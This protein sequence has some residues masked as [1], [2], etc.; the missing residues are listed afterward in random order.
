M[1][2]RSFIFLFVCAVLPMFGADPIYY[3][4]LDS[5]GDFSGYAW[6]PS[7]ASVVAALH[8]EYVPSDWNPNF[9]VDPNDPYSNYLVPISPDDYFACQDDSPYKPFSSDPAYASFIPSTPPSG[10]G[11][12]GGGSAPSGGGEGEGGFDPSST[13]NGASTVVGGLAVAVV[14]VIT[15][16]ALICILFIYWRK[17]KTSLHLC[18]DRYGR[19]SYERW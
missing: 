11:G 10:G 14:G 16:A 1:I 7:F 5:V 15:A 9:F 12:G 18:E 8:L 19:I 2:R 17:T 6:V 3:A 4:G 13:L